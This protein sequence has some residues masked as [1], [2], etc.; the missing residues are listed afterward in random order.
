MRKQKVDWLA[1]NIK[2]PEEL[3]NTYDYLQSELDIFLSNEKFRKLLDTID[4]T[5]HKGNVWREMR[6]VFKFRIQTWDIKNKTWYSY[7]LFEN[8]R[9]EL[10]SKKNNTLIWNELVNNSKKI[11]SKLMN[12]LHEKKLYPT[13]M[14]LKNLL[15]ANQTPIF[16][17]HSVLNLDYSISAAQ[18]FTIDEFN[19]CK[20]QLMNGKWLDYQILLP[21]SLNHNLTGRIAKPRFIK[22][23]SDGKYIGVCS[24]E[25][26]P[27]EN[28]ENNILGVDFGKIKYFSAVATNKKGEYS[29][30]FIQS[31]RTTRLLNELSKLY[32]EKAKLR[33]KIQRTNSYKNLIHTNKQNRRDLNYLSITHKVSRMKKTISKQTANEIVQVA[34]NLKCKEIHVENLSWLE[35]TGGKWD[36]SEIQ[37]RLKNKAKQ[38]G[39]KLVKVNAFNSSKNNPV[40]H[41]IGTVHNRIIRFNNGEEIDRDILAAIN[42]SIRTKKSNARIIPKLRKHHGTAKHTKS[43]SRRKVIKDFLNKIKRNTQIV[44]FQPYQVSQN[45]DTLWCPIFKDIPNCSL[46]TRSHS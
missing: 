3:K 25:Y 8:L 18:M 36:F 29:D 6:D 28:I 33:D 38:H 4:L 1:F 20:I 2:F 41:E 32:K 44:V 17:K 7:I 15:R 35:L 14:L 46:L 26:I 9:R 21:S 39:I 31:K 13:K 16:S 45:R 30:E 40:T 23:K 37:N 22:R 43:Q 24:Y 11:D 19:Y 12:N 5:Q 27:N 42:L 10:E 34:I